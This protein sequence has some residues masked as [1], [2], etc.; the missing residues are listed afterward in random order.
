MRP[1]RL[2]FFQYS[3]TEAAGSL[4]CGDY[5]I[6]AVLYVLTIVYCSRPCKLSCEHESFIVALVVAT[7][8]PPSRAV[9]H[10]GANI[11]ED[12][13]LGDSALAHRFKHNDGNVDSTVRRLAVASNEGESWS[14]PTNN[15]I[16]ENKRSDG[17]SRSETQHT[18][19]GCN[20]GAFPINY[21]D[22][23][24]T[25][26]ANWDVSVIHAAAD[27]STHV[28]DTSLDGYGSVDRSLK[29]ARDNE[30][31]SARQMSVSGDSEVVPGPSRAAFS[32][33]SLKRLIN[34]DSDDDFD[35]LRNL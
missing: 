9:G 6:F 20:I 12:A 35:E 18:V 33:S 21:M 1:W 7:L 3:S 19:A 24:D 26:D 17:P 29:R 16:I 2:Q 10:S 15:G 5:Y 14:Q 22:R 8:E 27:S 4:S 28:M 23:N 13:A 11:D 32:K 34:S 30:D 31:N 25:G